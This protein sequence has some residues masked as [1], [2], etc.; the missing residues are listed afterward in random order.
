MEIDIAIGPINL[1]IIT[2]NYYEFFIKGA[3][4]CHFCCFPA[5][6]MQKSFFLTFTR[7]EIIALK[8]K[9]KTSIHV[10]VIHGTILV[11]P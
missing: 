1:G 7:A 3:L 10:S 11:L 5:K 6:T 9:T 8:F 4:S 2:F